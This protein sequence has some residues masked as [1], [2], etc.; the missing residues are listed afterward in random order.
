M[1]GTRTIIFHLGVGEWREP[2]PI[3]RAN[4]RCRVCV[5]ARLGPQH[6]PQGTR[7]PAFAIYSRPCLA[8]R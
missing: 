7:S 2:M 5:L 8:A 6:L 1:R 4:M 3:C